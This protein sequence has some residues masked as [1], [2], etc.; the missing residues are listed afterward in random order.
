[1][2]M[3]EPMMAWHISSTYLMALTVGFPPIEV[4]E[5]P[6]DTG[7]IPASTSTFFTRDYPGSADYY[8]VEGWGLVYEVHIDTE[9]GSTILEK[10]LTASVGL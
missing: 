7:T 8:W 3:G 10:T 9:T 4:P 2:V 5:I 6:T 1:M